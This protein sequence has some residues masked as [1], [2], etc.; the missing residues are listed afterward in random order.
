MIL[1]T[2]LLLMIMGVLAAFVIGAVALP[3]FAVLFAIGLVLSI[4]VGIFKFIFGMPL[5]VILIIIGIVYFS[6][7]KNY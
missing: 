4:I 3:V 2:I 7:S 6:R 1:L 5:F